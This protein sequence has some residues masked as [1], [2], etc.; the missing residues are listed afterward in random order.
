MSLTPAVWHNALFRLLWKDSGQDLA[1]LDKLRQ[2][3]ESAQQN[4]DGSR[5]GK[6]QSCVEWPICQ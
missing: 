4:E 1:E 3:C 2:E 6:Q 5:V